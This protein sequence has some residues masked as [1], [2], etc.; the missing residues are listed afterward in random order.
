MTRQDL[1][2]RMLSAMTPGG[3]PEP[4]RR[5]QQRKSAQTRLRLVEAAVECLVA[6]GYA[7]LT[8]AAVAQMC[9]LS[10][11]A[12]HHHFTTRLELVAAVV[13]HV[14]RERMR[15]FLADYFAALAERGEEHLI[16]VASEANWHS[17]QTPEYAAY[18]ELVVAART[19]PELAALFEPAARRFDEVW[20][21]EMI[22]AFPQWRSHWDAMK[23]AS[24]FTMAV[25]MGLLLHRSMIGDGERLERARA[26]ATVTIRRLYDEAT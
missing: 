1:H 2:D 18:L 13:E 3:T 11:G 15:R 12:M 10:R 4:P 23:L 5:W 25:H 19:D 24:D 16:E 17:V 8:T 6:G 21:A 7:G 22:E 9:E 20:I 26:L 14:L